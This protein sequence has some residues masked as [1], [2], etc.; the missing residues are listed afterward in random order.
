MNS[1]LDLA[2][3]VNI[4]EQVK[5]DVLSTNQAIDNEVMTRK[6]ARNFICEC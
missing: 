5:V 2:N 6:V 3:P 4:A 1:S